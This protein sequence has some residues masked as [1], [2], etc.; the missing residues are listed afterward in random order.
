MLLDPLA[1]G[2]AG[3]QQHLVRPGKGLPQ[4]I[5]V[6]EVDRPDLHAAVGEICEPG[7]VPARGHDLIRR[8][9][10]LEEFF[11]DKAAEL[12]G[13]AGD[14]D[15]HGGPFT[16]GMTDTDATARNGILP[17]REYALSSKVLIWK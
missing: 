4:G 14:N 6:V 7:H 10:P 9:I 8:H 17:K 3:N 15:G 12:T 5:R 2:R 13:C 16:K 1:G 11:N